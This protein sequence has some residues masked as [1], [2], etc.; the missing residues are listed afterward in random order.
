MPTNTTSA[1][2]DYSAWIGFDSN[3]GV[4]NDGGINSAAHVWMFKRAKGFMDVVT[5]TGNGVQ[6]RNVNHSLGVVPEIMLI[7]R[8][9]IAASWV[10]YHAD[11][12]NNTENNSNN[13]M[14]YH[15][16][17]ATNTSGNGML[18]YTAPTS[19]VFTLDNNGYVNASSNT[20]IAYLF[21]SLNGVA[22]CG[23]YTGNGSSQNIACGFSNGARFVLIKR[24]DS[25]GDWYLWDTARGIVAGNDPHLSLNEPAAEVT[26]DSIDPVSSGF[27]VNQVAA[28]NINVTSAAYIFLAIA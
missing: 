14:I 2:V 18:N 25:S 4:I 19:S 8:R 23:S 17:D 13:S 28:T 7:K 9:N 15:L 24:T 12:W 20:Y 26:D 27:T 16:D 11:A 21:S 1:E 22:K 6:G 10:V 5:Y 3:T